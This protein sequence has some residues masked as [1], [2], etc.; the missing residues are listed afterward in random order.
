VDIVDAASQQLVWRGHATGTIE[1]E[2]AENKIRKAVAKLMEEFAK[3]TRPRLRSSTTASASP[4][5]RGDAGGLRKCW[6]FDMMLRSSS[7][8]SSS[9]PG[10]ASAI[11]EGAEIQCPTP[12]STAAVASGG[13]AAG[14]R[15]ASGV[16]GIRAAPAPRSQGV[17]AMS[18]GGW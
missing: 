15:C 3:D 1:P 4:T 5:V 9:G 12:R 13:A 10:G 17:H 2:E 18:R 16:T 14:G 6:G 8:G 11:S 7:A